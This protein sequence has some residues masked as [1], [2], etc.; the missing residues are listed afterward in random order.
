MEFFHSD[1]GVPENSAESPK[2]DLGMKGSGDG[3]APKVG[4]MAQADVAALLA[5]R[6]IAKLSQSANQVS[7]RNDGQLRTYRVT[8]TLP[9]STLL[10]SGISSPRLSRSSMQRSMASRILA[11]ASGT[12]LP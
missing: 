10:G 12:V 8:T 6:N 11:R 1:G 3:Q 7:F 9:I 4:R 2:G 5:H